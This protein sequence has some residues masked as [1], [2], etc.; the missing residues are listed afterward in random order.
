MPRNLKNHLYNSATIKRMLLLI[1]A[2][3]FCFV[4]IFAGVLLVYSPG[5]IEPYTDSGGKQLPGSVSEKIFV[6]IGGVEQGMFIRGK[7]VNNPVLLYVHGGPAFPNY[8]LIDKYEPGLE[9]HFTVC[10]WEQRGGGLSYNSEVTLESMNF[11]RFTDDAIEVTNYLRERFG[12]EKIYLMA[13][14]GG[15]PFAIMAAAKAPELFYA[16]I[17][18]SQ[19]TNQAES[20]KLAYKYMLEQYTTAGNENV[21]KEFEEFPLLDSAEYI[22]PFYKSSLRDNSMH[23]LGIGTMRNMRSVFSGVFLPVWMCRAY[24]VMEKVN[25]WISKFFFIK[26]TKL[27]EELFQTDIPAKVPKLEIPVYFF[28]GKYDLTVNHDLS[29]SYLNKLQAPVKGFYTFDNSAHS[30]LFEEPGKTKEILV[31]DVLQNQTSLADRN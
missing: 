8:F 25:I 4:L 11:D 20:E 9:D 2:I 27:I 18:M 19:I 6:N 22:I 28:S 24:T 23:E 7:N 13:H 14:S 26:K 10:Y 16:Y 30:P 31:K 3:L 29:K 12:K 21:V 17:G 1:F 15:T 5:N